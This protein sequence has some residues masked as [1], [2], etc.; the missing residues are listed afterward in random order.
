[1]ISFSAY[2]VMSGDFSCQT[3]L[4]YIQFL[5]S[6]VRNRGRVSTASEHR[7]NTQVT[8]DIVLRLRSSY[9][10]MELATSSKETTGVIRNFERFVL[11]EILGNAAGQTNA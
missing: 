8:G 11:S 3:A 5:C 2:R 10:L 4:T 1:M 9:K 7:L 6:G